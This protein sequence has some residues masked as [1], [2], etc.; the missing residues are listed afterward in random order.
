MSIHADI[1]ELQSILSE[2]AR[3]KNKL[4]ELSKL[5][6]NCETRILSY[7]ETH[8]QPGIKVNDKVLSIHVRKYR[9][10]LKMKDKL[11]TG[12]NTLKQYGIDI[13]P[14]VMAEL[15]EKMKGTQKDIVSLKYKN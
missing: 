5:K 8:N 10:H 1:K 9:Q 14:D 15:I 6:A 3:V 2:T 4:A 11:E 13:T 7:L 12:I